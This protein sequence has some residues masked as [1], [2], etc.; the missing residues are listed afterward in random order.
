MMKK[1][2]K[3]M[4]AGLGALSL[5]R[6]RAEKLFDEYVKHGQ[7]ARQKHADIIKKLM[8]EA[9]KKR[10][11]LERLIGDQIKATLGKLNVATKSDL[12]RLEAKIDRLRAGRK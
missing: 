7:V 5:S 10:A 9:G 4:L 8:S 2:D 12:S 1:L 3:L 6:D 11:G